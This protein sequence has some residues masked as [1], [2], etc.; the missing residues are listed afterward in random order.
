MKLRRRWGRA[1]RTR[2]VEFS[3]R[4][5]RWNLTVSARTPIAALLLQ[6]LA[7]LKRYRRL[8][9]G[10]PDSGFQ[11]VKLVGLS[12]L[13]S[14]QFGARFSSRFGQVVMRLRTALG[15]ARFDPVGTPSHELLGQA[16][17]GGAD[18]RGSSC[19]VQH[20]HQSPR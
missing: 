17:P 14:Q 11:R 7:T 1:T 18:L 5:R 15:G 4:E 12:G 2:G 16:L 13:G 8:W 20:P 6:A 19:G 9:L 3:I 10:R